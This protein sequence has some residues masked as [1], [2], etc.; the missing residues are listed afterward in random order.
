MLCHETSNAISE[1]ARACK[2]LNVYLL[3]R[4][5]SARSTRSSQI[6]EVFKQSQTDLNCTSYFC[7]TTAKVFVS[8]EASLSLGRSYIYFVATSSWPR[9]EE[10]K[11]SSQTGSDQ[12]PLKTTN[13]G[14][15]CINLSTIKI[16]FHHGHGQPYWA[17]AQKYPTT[18]IARAFR[19]F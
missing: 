6:L 14:I 19:N 11:L 3:K 13:F 1:S 10:V 16:R 4:F 12:D 17:S 15:S 2:W 7:F 5:H 8:I 9:G 18:N